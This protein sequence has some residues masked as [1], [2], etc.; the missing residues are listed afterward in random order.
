LTI[1]RNSNSSSQRLNLD[2]LQAM[3]SAERSQILLNIADA[4]VKNEDLILKENGLDLQ[5]A[6]ESD[7]ANALLQRLKLKPGK[8]SCPILCIFLGVSGVCVNILEFSSSLG[9]TSLRTQKCFQRR[10]ARSAADACCTDG[11]RATSEVGANP[12]A[13]TLDSPVHVLRST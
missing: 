1:C 11:E 10:E 7:T 13:S 8:V 6:Q 5:Q 4:L 2:V 3:T 9:R 12:T